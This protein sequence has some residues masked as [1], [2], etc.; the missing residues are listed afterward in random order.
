MIAS[1][2][3]GDIHTIVFKGN[4]QRFD[5]FISTLEEDFNEPKFGYNGELFDEDHRD[6]EE[7]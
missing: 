4:K 5:S 2:S 7:D 1:W 3:N 6:Y